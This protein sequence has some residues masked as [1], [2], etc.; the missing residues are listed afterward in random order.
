M[1]KIKESSVCGC[2]LIHRYDD[3]PICLLNIP[4]NCLACYFIRLIRVETGLIVTRRQY[5]LSVHD[6]VVMVALLEMSCVIMQQPL[7]QSG[8]HLSTC[9]TR[10]EGDPCRPTELFLFNTHFSC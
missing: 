1:A 3:N 5:A 7:D 6:L 8:T 2:D 9:Y 10:G 4:P